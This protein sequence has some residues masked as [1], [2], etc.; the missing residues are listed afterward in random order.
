MPKLVLG[1]GSMLVVLAVFYIPMRFL[2][3]TKI[4]CE[5]TDHFYPHEQVHSK[6]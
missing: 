5:M 4:Y 1:I 6:N 3:E 2:D